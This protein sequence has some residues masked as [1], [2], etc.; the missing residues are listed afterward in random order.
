MKRIII[1]LLLVILV[2]SLCIGCASKPK[3]NSEAVPSVSAPVTESESDITFTDLNKEEQTVLLAQLRN[4]LTDTDRRKYHAKK[5]SC[6]NTC[7]YCGMH[8]DVD[9]KDCASAKTASGISARPSS[10]KE[11]PKWE[12]TISVQRASS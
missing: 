2:C 4:T 3:D 5:I 8:A 11:R 12:Q 9:R 7:Q 10:C 1:T 6:D